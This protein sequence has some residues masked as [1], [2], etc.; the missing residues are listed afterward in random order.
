MDAKL[1]P[2]ADAATDEI[3]RE[4]NVAYLVDGSLRKSGDRLPPASRPRCWGY[5]WWGYPW[6]GWGW[7]PGPYYAGDVYYYPD[8]SG[9]LVYRLAR[10]RLARRRLRLAWRLRLARLRL[11]RRLLGSRLGLRRRA[12]R[13]D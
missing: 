4:L 7:G 9:C 5:P 6:W 1:N 2:A 10:W 12:R 11:A 13:R 3:G 8:N